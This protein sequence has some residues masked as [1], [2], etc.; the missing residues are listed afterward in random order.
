[1]SFSFDWANLAFGS[2]KPLKD[3]KATFIAAPRELSAQ[4]FTQLVKALL[5]E[6]NLLVGLAKEKFVVGFEGQPQFLTLQHD[7]IKSVIDKV[8]SSS[9]KHKIYTLQYA[10]PELSYILDKVTF[11]LVILVNGSWQYSFHTSKPYYQLA[12]Q[13]AAFA[14]VSPFVD[15]AEAQAYQVYRGKEIATL[16]P[17]PKANSLISETEMMAAADIAAKYSYDYSYQTGLAVGKKQGQR[18]RF[19]AAAH[20]VVVPYETYALHHGNSREIHLSPPHDLNHYDT[21]HAEVELL[22]LAIKQGIKLKGA[23]IFINLLPC[24]TCAR[25]LADSDISEIVYQAD[26]SEGYAVHMLEAA[27]KHVRRLVLDPPKY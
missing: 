23:S 13:Q 24:P 21:V 15:Q 27:G 20:N 4:R 5:P 1:M 3:L 8:N 6:T 19:L 14:F 18:Y 7:N 22:L 16:W 9:S 17:L 12:N 11:P 26:H 2:K 25:V 10:Q